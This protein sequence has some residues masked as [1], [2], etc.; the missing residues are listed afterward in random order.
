MNGKCTVISKF[1]VENGMETEVRDAFR[2][3]PG[4][5]DNRE[6]FLGLSV[7]CP[8]E[9]S[10]EFWLITHWET[11]AHFQKWHKHHKSESHIGIPTGLKLVKHS[12]ELRHFD[13][14]TF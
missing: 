4:F 11:E 8:K 1:E 3:R 6:G 14:V 10:S 12:F 13:L 2:N 5:V 9:N 7:I